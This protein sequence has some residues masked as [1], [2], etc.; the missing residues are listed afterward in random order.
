MHDYWVHAGEQ[1]SSLV[2]AVPALP[3]ALT[4][5]IPCKLLLWFVNS[6]E[7]FSGPPSFRLCSRGYQSPQQVQVVLLLLK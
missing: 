6:C 7:V 5:H 1:V 3:S 4:F 2:C